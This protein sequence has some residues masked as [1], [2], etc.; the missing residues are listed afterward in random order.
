MTLKK[1][2]ESVQL[3]NRL[4]GENSYILRLKDGKPVVEYK[5]NYINA[6]EFVSRVKNAVD[7]LN[8]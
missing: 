4:T 8:F 2:Y 1:V 6:E 7:S 5:G 3:M